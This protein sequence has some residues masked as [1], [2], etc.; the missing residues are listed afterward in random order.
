MLPLVPAEKLGGACAQVQELL[1]LEGADEERK[2]PSMGKWAGHMQSLHSTVMN[3][4]RS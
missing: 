3:T 4:T 2:Y 1:E